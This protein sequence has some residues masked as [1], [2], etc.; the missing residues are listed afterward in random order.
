[1][2]IWYIEISVHT[3][4]KMKNFPNKFFYRINFEKDL[5][6]TLPLKP[7]LHCDKAAVSATKFL[8]MI[9]KTFS[10]SRF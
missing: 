5:R 10:V 4:Y 9:R 1:M 8:R 3:S 6:I 7:S 2:H